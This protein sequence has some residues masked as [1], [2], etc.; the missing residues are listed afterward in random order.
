ML[1]R[2]SSTSNN[3][4]HVPAEMVM[5]MFKSIQNSLESV[6]EVIKKLT[7]GQVM[8]DDS[9]KYKVCMAMPVYF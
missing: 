5:Q 3:S 1:D 9:S 4:A 7:P 6:T 8:G 2:D